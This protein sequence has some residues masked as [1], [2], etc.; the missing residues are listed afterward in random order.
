MHVCT[1]LYNVYV[2]YSISE[3]KNK[4]I[5]GKK[6]KAIAHGFFQKLGP[7]SPPIFIAFPD[8]Y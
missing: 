4:P 8:T 5:F 6:A 2:C 7:K 3:L 1:F